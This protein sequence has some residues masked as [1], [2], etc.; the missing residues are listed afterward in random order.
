V[1]GL[2]L[3]RLAWW[4]AGPLIFVVTLCM[5]SF[6][7]HWAGRWGLQVPAIEPGCTWIHA[8][9]VGEGRAAEAIC[10]ALTSQRTGHVLL[11]TATSQ[12]GLEQAR[13]QH[14]QS[15]LPMD[16]PWV[17]RG[18]LNKVRPSVLVLVESELWPN[19]LLGCLG[20]GIPVIV[21][22]ARVG[23]G[24]RRFKRWCPWL[25]KRVS[26]SVGLWLAVDEDTAA[27]LQA[28]VPGRVDVGGEPKSDALPSSALVF[29]RPP[30]VAGST[31]SGEE[32]LLLASLEG[33]VDPPV[34][35]LAPRHPSRF[36]EVRELLENSGLR[37]GLRSEIQT[38][39]DAETQVLLLDSLGELAGLYEGA[40][41]AFVGGTFLPH[42]GGHSPVEP[43]SRG[44]P[45]VCGPY[46]GAHRGAWSRLEPYVALE[47]NGLAGALQGAMDAEVAPVFEL[48]ASVRV[49]SAVLENRRAQPPGERALR[50]LLT[51]LGWMWMALVSYR[52]LFWSL[53]PAAQTGG[54][55]ISVGSLGSGGAGKTVVTQW[56]VEALEAQ[57]VPSAV[58]SR[59]YGRV[60]GGRFVRT[61]RERS[62]ASWL[63]D[64]P[65]ML[66]ARGCRVV[67]S[68]NRVA[69]A[70]VAF[71][72]GAEVVV[73]DDAFQHRRIA[74]D[75]DI[76]VMDGR[77]PE[78]GGAIP[79]G[80]RREP[81]D[82]LRRA[83]VVWVRDGAVPEHLR[84]GLRP[85]TLVVQ[86]RVVSV[87][88][89]RGN[90]EHPLE[91]LEDRAVCAFAGIARP[92]RF[93][94]HLAG[95]GVRVKGWRVFRDHHP[96]S[97][98]DV[99]QLLSWARG[100][101]LVTT[102]KDRVRLPE[103]IEVWALRVRTEPYEGVSE[104]RAR[105]ADFAS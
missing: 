23:R 60:R 37:W 65:A 12:T 13:G 2:A 46:T 69:G 9:S 99:E 78:E 4:I 94:E 75:L 18:W 59:G 10:E 76:V 54:R 86:A 42:I 73:L 68:P 72:Q 57:G 33:L 63:G 31:R 20:R 101:P 102:E 28:C 56:L 22:S 40:A 51:P 81:L 58:V 1:I 38:E 88:W 70:E 53:F 3:Y 64:E 55:V 85:T 19:L 25:F 89:L 77:W 44:V 80:E 84:A 41:A 30:I 79:S 92:G 17:V 83:D 97:E 74:R 39:V 90:E 45:L 29:S 14:V 96:F 104:L 21:A 15:P 47:P 6:R 34:L 100:R 7:R 11:R 43:A 24:T 8:A 103:D 71:S 27:W 50:P 91:A 62:D 105:L 49:A 61:A 48:G 26:R 52:N 87:C 5:P 98:T 67:S 32:A 66:S 35:V 82:S 95:L 16:H 93:L 36:G